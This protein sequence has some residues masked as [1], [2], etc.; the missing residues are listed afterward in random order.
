MSYDP[1]E[2]NRHREGAIKTREAEEAHG[3]LRTAL[4]VALLGP[5]AVGAIVFFKV[6]VKDWMRWG[7][8]GTAPIAVLFLLINFFRIPGAAKFSRKAIL[9]A[10]LTLAAAAATIPLCRQFLP[11]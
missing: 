6:E 5:L 10:I 11:Q 3:R 8:Y 2:F 4:F 9:L 1:D 7:I